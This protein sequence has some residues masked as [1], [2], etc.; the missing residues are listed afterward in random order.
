MDALK[1]RR[2]ASMQKVLGH[3]DVLHWACENGCFWSKETAIKFFAGHMRMG[4]VFLKPGV[5]RYSRCDF[6]CVK[7]YVCLFA[8]AS[9]KGYLQMG[10]LANTRS[11]LATYIR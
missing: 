11:R 9:E 6:L 7:M 10:V 4:D 8:N 5:N 2:L 3:L 1:M